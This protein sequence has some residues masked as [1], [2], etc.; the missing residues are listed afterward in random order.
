MSL[1]GLANLASRHV[2]PSANFF[3]GVF[4]I[5]CGTVC[6]LLPE[7]TFTDPWPMGIVF[8][9]GEWAGG[10]ILHYDNATNASF[11]HMVA[12]LMGR[13]DPNER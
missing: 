13:E 5:L 7:I 2:L 12:R 11:N 6:L 4:Y 8:F 10:W 9:I 3:V 1:F